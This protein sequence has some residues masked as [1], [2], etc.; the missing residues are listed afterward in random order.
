MRY[1]FLILTFTSSV[2]LNYSQLCNF[3]WFLY[4]TS[5]KAI[6]KRVAISKKVWPG[7]DRKWK[8]EL[9]LLYSPFIVYHNTF[10]CQINYIILNKNNTIG[11]TICGSIKYVFA[12][13]PKTYIFS[14]SN[15]SSV[16]SGYKKDKFE[17]KR[18]IDNL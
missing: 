13:T 12:G 1:S 10:G 14:V 6:E 4:Q 11:G 18:R 16:W 17:R 5:E 3:R 15:I 8:G 7:E 2:F 9:T